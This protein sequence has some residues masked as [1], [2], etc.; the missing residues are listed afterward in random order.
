MCLKL[1]QGPRAVQKEGSSVFNILNHVV[2]ADIRC[3]VACN[4]VC[5]IDQISRLDRS[6]SKTKV[7]NSDTTGFFGV[8]IEICLCILISIITN[9]LDGVLVCTDRTVSTKTPELAADNGIRNCNRVIG[10]I[11]RQVCYIVFDTN[12]KQRFFRI[13]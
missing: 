12:S 9:D 7:G 6:L 2:F 5:L 11:Q 8:V 3:I 4:E 13:S 10:S 1:F